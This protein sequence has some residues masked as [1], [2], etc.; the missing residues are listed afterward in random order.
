MTFKEDASNRVMTFMDDELTGRDIFWQK[1]EW[2]MAF[3]VAF[4]DGVM[5]L[6]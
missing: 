3:L 4:D 2:V 5:T 6:F 1:R